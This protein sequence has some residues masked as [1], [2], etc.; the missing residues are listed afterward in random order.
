MAGQNQKPE[1]NEVPPGLLAEACQM[2]RGVAPSRHET[3]R[4]LRAGQRGRIH[5]LR[6]RGSSRHFAR[7]NSG[8]GQGEPAGCAQAGVGVPARTGGKRSVAKR[9]TRADRVCRGMKLREL[10][11]HLQTSRNST[12][13]SVTISRL[14]SLCSLSEK[15]CSDSFPNDAQT[16]PRETPGTRGHVRKGSGDERG[17]IGY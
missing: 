10:E 4:G 16:I 12:T 9:A 11:R 2:G 3:D 7:R 15:L 13:L 1:A 6:G 17:Q 8:L 14:L 5:L